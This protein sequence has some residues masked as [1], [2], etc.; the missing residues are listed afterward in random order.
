M[1]KLSLGPGSRGLNL[2]LTIALVTLLL[3]AAISPL[4][5][6]DLVVLRCDRNQLELARDNLIA[7]N[8]RREAT[9]AQLHADDAFLQRLIHQ[10]LGYV[11]ADEMIYRFSDRSNGEDQGS[12]AP[13]DSGK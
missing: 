10:E 6:R 13:P 2:I 8:A 12:G 4:G 1:A 7:Q 11:R 5:L 3:D 9:I